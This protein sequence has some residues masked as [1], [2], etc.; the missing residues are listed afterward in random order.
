MTVDEA[1]A[2]IHSVRWQSR[3]PGLERVRRLLDA[4][5][6]PQHGLQFVHVAGTNGKGSTCACIAS[7]LQAA[8]YRAGLYTSP[9]L[10]RFHERFRVNGAEITDAQLC[11]LVEEVRPAAD[12]LPEAPTEFEL[13]TAMAMCHFRRQRCDIVVL[14]VGLGGALDP[15]NVIDCPA[16]A[17]IT[18]IGL[19]HTRE[20]GDTLG[21]IAAAKAGILKPGGCALSLGGTPEADAVMEAAARARGVRLETLDRSRLAVRALEPDCT[22]MDFGPY[23]G[24]RLPLLGS[25]QPENAA[26]AIAAALALRREGWAIPDAAIHRGIE[27]VRWPGRFELLRREP[28]FVLDGAHNPQGVRAAA[29]SLAARWPGRQFIYLIGILADKDAAHML[30]PLAAQARAFVTLTPP[31]P[32]AL[33]ADA[34]A[35]MLSE[36][37]GLP[38]YPAG[39]A[40]E[41]V[42]L[43]LRLAGSDGGVCALGSLYLSHPIRAAALALPAKGENH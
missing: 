5:G 36:R 40:Q 3:K 16:L 30:A 37:T 18:A 8:G 13:I 35:R 22:V 15:T 31:S 32:R 7:I 24:L 14:E 20:L 34:L 12:S 17:V 4:L 21:Q 6:N 42:A 43:A 25:Y 38:A 29:E 27:T 41:G 23:T 10:R 39:T 11:A 19:D 2:Y 28:P 33:S 1:L 26:L 9:F